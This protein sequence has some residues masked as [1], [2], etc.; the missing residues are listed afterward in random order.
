[1]N[2]LNF[3][4]LV[5]FVKHWGINPI[6]YPEISTLIFDTEAPWNS[7]KLPRSGSYTLHKVRLCQ[8]INHTLNVSVSSIKKSL[9]FLKYKSMFLFFAACDCDIIFQYATPWSNIPKLGRYSCISLIFCKYPSS[10]GRASMVILLR[11]SSGW[12]T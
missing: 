9:S 1:M 5:D 3:G 12:Y 4:Q 8:K 2:F 11:L 10:E 6:R 7:I